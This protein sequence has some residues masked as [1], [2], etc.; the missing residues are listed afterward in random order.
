[1]DILKNFLSRFLILVLIICC[2][3]FFTNNER[4]IIDG[5]EI[6]NDSNNKMKDGAY[7]KEP[8]QKKLNQE[9]VNVTIGGIKVKMTKLAEYDITGVVM[10]TEI[11][12]DVVGPIDVGLAWGVLSENDNYKD[13]T[14]YEV[15][16]RTLSW[17]SN[18][19]DWVEK[20]GGID[21]IQKSCSNNHLVP[22]TDEIRK[23]LFKIQK[24]EYIRIVGYLVKLEW[25][26][27]QK[28]HIWGPSSLSRGDSGGNACEIIYV[29]KINFL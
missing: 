18:D 20:M 7:I 13:F 22:S 12:N 2:I 15:Q 6:T 19:A 23:E 8:E 29:Q 4:E 1:M 14:S 10:D 21:N 28:Q 5:E 25:Q 17:M 11:Y 26:V 24:D 3:I 9:I 16:N 27:G